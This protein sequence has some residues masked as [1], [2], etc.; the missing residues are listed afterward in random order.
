MAEGRLVSVPP[1][2][3]QLDD[4]D[5]LWR[6]HSALL[7]CQNLLERATAKEEEELGGGR[8]GEYENQRKMV[9]ERLSLLILSTGELMKAA[10]GAS[11]LTPSLEGLEVGS[12]AT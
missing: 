1:P 5:K 4:R 8:T 12:H 10:D 3:S 7:Q 2:S 6:I 11:I 9:K